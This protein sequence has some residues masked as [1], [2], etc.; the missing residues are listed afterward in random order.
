M[1]MLVILLRRDEDGGD[2]AG[3]EDDGSDI[4]GDGDI[5]GDEDGDIA[6][7]EDDGNDGGDIADQ[8]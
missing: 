6:G 7:D 2:I 8:C 5:A 4:A 1:K 3:D